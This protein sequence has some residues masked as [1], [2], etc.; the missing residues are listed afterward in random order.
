MRFRVWLYFSGRKLGGAAKHQ[1]LEQMREARVPGFHLVARPGLHHD[2]HRHDVGVVRRHRDQ[3][4]PVGQVFLRVG[5]RKNLRGL[6]PEKQGGACE[7][8]K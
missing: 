3:A 5:I 7:E 6:R 1:V 8:Q 4:Q 2:V